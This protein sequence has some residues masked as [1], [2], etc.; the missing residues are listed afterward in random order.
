MK[1]AVIAS[2]ILPGLF[3]IA[4]AETSTGNDFQTLLNIRDPFRKISLSATA[5]VPRTPLEQFPSD[6]FKMVGVLT[7]PERMRAMVQDPDGKTHVVSEKMKIGLRDGV[8]HR[9]AG[10]R[11]VIREKLTSVLGQIED[12]DTPLFMDADARS[13]TTESKK[14]QNKP[15]QPTQGQGGLSPGV[16]GK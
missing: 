7:G 2:L 11:I 3:S 6:S 4:R 10:D 13:G 5:K 12:V 9:I 8:I 14:S 16:G 1:R 15:S